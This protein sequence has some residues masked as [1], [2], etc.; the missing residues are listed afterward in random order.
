MVFGPGMYRQSAVRGSI[1]CV[2][3]IQQHSEQRFTE[4]FLPRRFPIT[5]TALMLILVLIFAY[6]VVK[7]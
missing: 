6:I 2:V 3:L 1:A 4:T 5:I 7:A